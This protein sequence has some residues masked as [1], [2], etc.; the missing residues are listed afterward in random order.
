MINNTLSILNLLQLKDNL[1]NYKFVKNNINGF[2]TSISKLKNSDWLI[3]IM[4][5]QGFETNQNWYF[6]YEIKEDDI[7]EVR[8]LPNYNKEYFLK[9][10]NLKSE[11][12]ALNRFGQKFHY[13]C[14]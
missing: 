1:T 12:E 13:N 3:D 4:L 14:K 5:R 2:L 10:Y 6:D 9:E 8:I 7:L 11:L